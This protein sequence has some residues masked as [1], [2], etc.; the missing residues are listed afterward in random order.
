[1]E[2]NEGGEGEV[3]EGGEECGTG[4]KRRGRRGGRRGIRV[5][6][7]GGRARGLR[8]ATNPPPPPPP[9][10]HQFPTEVHVGMKITYSS[11]FII[12]IQSS[13]VIW[14]WLMYHSPKFLW[15]SPCSSG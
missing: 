4:K 10:P 12:F 5:H 6:V 8:G 14:S 1:M 11:S 15:S 2:W 13:S 3:V 7:L 9:P